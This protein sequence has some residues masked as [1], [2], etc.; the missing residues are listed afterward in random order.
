MKQLLFLL[1]VLFATTL[2]A[3]NYYIS[4]A[5]NDGSDGMT[6]ATAWQTLSKINSYG[7][8]S[9]DVILLRRGDSFYGSIVVPGSNLS[10]DAYG[11][12]AKPVITGFTTLSSWTDAGGGVWQISAPSVK[13]TINMVTLNDVAQ[14]VGRYPNADAPNEGYLTGDTYSGNTQYSCAALGGTNWTGAEV[15][16]RLRG[17][18]VER[19]TITAQSGS[20]ITYAQTVATINPKNAGTPAPTSPPGAGFGL[21]IQRDIRT[22]D[23][24]GEWYFNPSTKVMS[25]YFGAA[26]PASYTIRA[27]SVDTLI[28]IDTKNNITV[29]NL[30][31][32]GANLAAVYFIDGSNRTIT[33]CTINNSGAKGIFGWYSFNT[34]IDGNTINSSMCGGIDIRAAATNILV[35]NNTVTNTG[36]LKGMSSFYD[37]ADCNGIYVG[38]N[39]I[40]RHNTIDNVGYIG[41]HYEGVSVRVDSNYINH[42]CMLRN[43]GGGIY[44][45]NNPNSGSTV[46]NNIILN[47]GN[48]TEGT[49]EFNGSHGIYMD[50]GQGGVQ[51]QNNTIANLSGSNTYGLFFNSPKNITANYNT[52]YNSNG[53]YVGRQADQN[54]YG[55]VFK[56][57]VIFNTSSSQWV[58]QHTNNGLNATTSP[59][60]STIQQSLQQLGLIDSNN[61]NMPN[62]A[63]F[64][65]YYATTAG[66]GFT[67]PAP[68]NFTAW[69]S[70]S[71]LDAHSK[72]SN[73][74]LSTQ[75]FKYN[76]GDVPLVFNFSGLSKKDVYGTVYNNAATIPAWSSVILID[77]GSASG[78]NIPPV[79][80]AGTDKTIILPANTVNLAGT[81]TDADGTISSY[82][83]VSISGPS[84]PAIATASAAS[85]AVNNLV[86]GIYKYE[87][88]VTDNNGA[89][90]KDTVQVTV[91]TITNQPP[92]A[93]A[94]TDKTIILPVNTTTLAGSGTDPNGTISTYK[95]VSIS[96]PSAGTIAAANAASTVINN[97]VQGIYKYELTVTDNNGATAKDTVQV[98]VN[99]ITNQPPAAN[100]GTDKT[101]ILPVNTTTLAG[102]GTVPNGT[103]SSYKWL[104]ISG[105]STPTIAT[106]NAASTAVNNLVQG[107]YKYELTVTDNN[108]ATGKDTVQ[109]TVNA[110]I[111]V[112]PVANAGTDKSITLPTNTAT[113]TG[114]ATDANGTIINYAWAKV[115]GPSYGTI[116]SINAA[117]TVLN[118]LAKGIYK[119]ELTVTD[120]NGAIGRDTVQVIVN[121]APKHTVAANAGSNKAISLPTST[122]TLT[123]TVTDSTGPVISYKW[124][125][126]SG[127][128]TGTIITNNSIKT[129]VK[130]LVEGTY[131]YEFSIMDKSGLTAKDTVQVAVTA[132]FSEA[133]VANAGTDKA[134]TLPVN[135]IT[136]TGSGTVANSSIN[137]Y[138]WTK[139]SGPGSGAIVTANAANTV[140]NN[141]IQ[142][143]YKYQLAVTAKN[144]LTAKDTVQI[145]VNA[146]IDV[147]PTAN[148]GTDKAINLPIN[149]ITLTGSGTV[150]NSIISGYAWT[151]IS[152][153]ASGTIVT[154]NAA[155]TVI[156]NL[157][158]GIYKYQLAV[159]ANSGL[160]A[161]DTVQVTV[162]A[163]IIKNQLPAA[164]AGADINIV[165]PADSAQ[166]TG[167]GTDAD[168]TITAYNWKVIT[169]PAGYLIAPSNAKNA[170]IRQLVQGVYDIE[171]TV[172]DNNG[173]IAKDTLRLTVSSVAAP[174]N[175]NFYSFRVYPN[176]VKDIANINVTANNG[177]ANS[178]VLLSVVNISGIVVKSKVLLT[179]GSSTIFK[180]DMSDLGDGYYI[181]VL[182][183]ENGEKSSTKVIKH[184]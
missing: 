20:T 174:A 180:L 67:F 62:A 169:G 16:A 168:G 25:M 128:S 99:A 7:F 163:T 94:G 65:W 158:Q 150:A 111:N 78:G 166:L 164:N 149:T 11:T 142:G 116:V 160:T 84:T 63:P 83:W 66:G 71:N 24:L 119:Y 96:G 46:K 148:A 48:P 59:V 91:N 181:I 61:Y 73:T 42:Y 5:G 60:V 118:N 177:T 127:P 39:T 87:L 114:S 138:A 184:S 30:A 81:G 113:L 37:P 162:N 131:N 22:L 124:V 17:Y 89:T 32:E 75:V 1:S 115:A 68:D 54:M 49:Q 21:F 2:Q 82:N 126:I 90:G 109:V 3:K 134:I 165:M 125:K 92:A 69:Q 104:S 123:G 57:N 152:G 27:S 12:G 53:W 159:T 171:L 9:G 172:T 88:T 36:M 100:A 70:Y 102:S 19:N 154:A 132:L 135:T 117:A 76:P 41:I 176:P 23:K 143:V 77:N 147:A 175:T 161:R 55:F 98:T 108:G 44:A 74:V 107:I 140:I 182:T 145:T 156:N 6:A 10:F 13:S 33:N 40:V 101:I 8:A 31:F 95:W 28:N 173:A 85:T 146:L 58:M 151:K 79:A 170:T 122:T 183:F 106:P 64:S 56:G 72:N 144:G 52:V 105:P 133:P 45:Y 130:N 97:L 137:G 26:N 136:L 129:E 178:K 34:L 155:T 157:V 15:V 120:N 121:A 103:I 35:T 38:A 86:Q 29:N 47:A 51:I 18:I 141:L 4:A 80:N 93:N 14:E 179:Q 112:A 43:D 153:P 139:I 50:G 167:A 110:L